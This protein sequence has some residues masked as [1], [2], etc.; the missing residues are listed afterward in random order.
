[1]PECSFREQ[2]DKAI[3]GG[4][5]KALV[6]TAQKIAVQMIFKNDRGVVESKSVSTSQ[7]RNI[8]GATK[9]IDMS[10][11]ADNA[12]EKYSSLLLLK[13]KMAYANG[14]HNKGNNIQGFTVLVTCLS[15]AIDQVD[16]QFNRMKNFFN[17]F[18][19]ILAY[20]KAEGGK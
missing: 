1:M 19:A 12:S 18:E 15:H 5:A 3:I 11:N 14:R 20:H 6:D 17:F 10:L 2:I 8:Y 16:G 13:P 7:I 9:K 4:D